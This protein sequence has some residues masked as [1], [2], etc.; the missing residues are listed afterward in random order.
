MNAPASE[1]VIE[2]LDPNDPDAMAAWHATYLASNVHQ[3]EHATPWQLEEIRAQLRAEDNPGSRALAWSG[4]VDGQVLVVGAL[5]LPLMDNLTQAYVEVNT[6]PSQRNRGLGSAM[7]EHLIGEAERH[8]RTVLNTEAAYPYDGPADGAGHAY[9]DFLTHRGFTFGLG[10]VQRVLDLPADER[11]LQGLVDEA[12]PYHPGYQIRQ[13]TGPVPD[14]IL[15]SFGRLIGS[16][17]TEAPT[18]EL[19]VEGEVFDADRIRADEKVFEESGRT[20]YTTVAIAPDGTVAAYSEL[21][22]PRYDP[23]RVFQWGTLAHPEHRGHRLGLATKA[24]NLLWLQRERDDLRVLTTYNAEVNSH[25][26][27]VNERMGFRP[28]ERLGEFQRKL[29]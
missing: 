18:G 2:R 5:D 12:T 13:F 7:L 8:G 24:R 6:L 3:R 22:V 1:L 25:M 23:G 15:D 26:I 4:R 17:M 10:D 28:V 14:D 27:G 16:L 19:E 21:V 29:I 11:M 20:K 9:A